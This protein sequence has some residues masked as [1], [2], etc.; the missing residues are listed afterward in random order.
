[1]R[2]SAEIEPNKDQTIALAQRMGFEIEGY[3]R[4]AIEGRRDALMLGMTADTCR[5]VRRAPRGSYGP[6]NEVSD[7]KHSQSA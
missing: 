5:F 2:I 7:G 4:K 3:K 6:D 1:V